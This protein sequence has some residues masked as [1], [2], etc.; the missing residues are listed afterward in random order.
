M[1]I[2][3]FYGYDNI[4]SSLLTLSYRCGII[5]LSITGDK[6][7][8]D[9]MTLWTPLHINL[10]VERERIQTPRMFNAKQRKVLLK[11]VDLF[12]EGNLAEM[13]EIG[14]CDKNK[15]LFDYPVWE[16]LDEPFYD[17]VRNMTMYGM[18]Y[19]RKENI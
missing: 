11:L 15:A 17:V 7:M 3:V 1:Y 9:M 14:Q 16:F 5:H 8:A 4:Q 18:E 2:K 10:R 13:V 19:K 6:I 12:E